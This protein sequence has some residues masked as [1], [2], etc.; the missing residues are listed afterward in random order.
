MK[1]W[2]AVMPFLAACYSW[3]PVPTPLPNN[4]HLGDVRVHPCTGRPVVLHDT[5]IVSDSLAGVFGEESPFESRAPRAIPVDSLCGLDRHTVNTLT[6]VV[7]T[8]GIPI[9]AGIVWLISGSSIESASP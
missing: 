1:P 9:A 3:E 2:A 7:V 4:T 5:R 8:V 6:T